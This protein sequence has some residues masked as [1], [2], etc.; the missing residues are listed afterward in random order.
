MRWMHS[1]A[2]GALNRPPP[3]NITNFAYGVHTPHGGPIQSDLADGPPFGTELTAKWINGERTQKNVRK[4]FSGGQLGFC[5]SADGAGNDHP[6]GNYRLNLG[7][8]FPLLRHGA[9]PV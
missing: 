2:L 6:T 4:C 3:A 5:R 7:N 1:E 8:L 9:L